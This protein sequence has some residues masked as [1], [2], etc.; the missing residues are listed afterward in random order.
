MQEASAFD[1]QTSFRNCAAFRTADI[2]RLLGISPAIM[3]AKRD[4]TETASIL[5]HPNT[6]PSASVFRWFVRLKGFQVL[7]P[8][9]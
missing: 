9:R 6:E 5:D 3:T 2:D 1:I 8:A 7:T 4:Q